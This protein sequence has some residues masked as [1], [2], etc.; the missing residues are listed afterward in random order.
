MATVGL[1]DRVTSGW[2]PGV[3]GTVC[4][5]KRSNL[6]WRDDDYFIE[7]DD[8]AVEWIAEQYLELAE[9]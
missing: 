2:H 6:L 8:G 4:D 3:T 7:F 9:D 1:G 5:L